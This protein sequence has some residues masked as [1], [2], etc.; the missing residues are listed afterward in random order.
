MSVEL[1]FN[2]LS[3]RQPVENK[4]FARQIM[5]E[6]VACVRLVAEIGVSAS[7]RADT[8]IHDLLLAPDYPIAQWRNDH[9]VDREERRYFRLINSK[10]PVLADLPNI[11]ELVRLQEFRFE[12][13]LANGLGI[14]ELIGGLAISFGTDRKWAQDFVR[15]EVS[16]LNE[17][18]EIQ[19]LP[20]NVEHASST[21]HVESHRAW[22]RSRLTDEL[23]DGKQ[24][25]SRRNEIFPKLVLC[26]SVGRRLT[27]I[28]PGSLAIRVI[29]HRLEQLNNYC[30]TWRAGAF[31]PQRLG[32]HASIESQPTLQQYG[33]QRTFRCPDGRE[34]LFSWH[35]RLPGAWRLHFLPDLVSRTIIIGYIGPHLPTVVFQN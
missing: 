28:D 19:K 29:K 21:Q 16:S 1:V 24:I 13:E 7:L 11:A 2:E 14:A 26:E 20:A 32:L 22:I 31:D 15:I 10:V 9:E 34:Q 17:R 12:G 5:T 33:E 25:W 23:E 27:E 8:S 6:F 30:L 35:C 4:S 3:L 18:E